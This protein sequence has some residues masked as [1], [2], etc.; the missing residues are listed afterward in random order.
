MRQE[1]FIRERVDRG[2]TVKQAQREYASLSK[3]GFRNLG[4]WH[5]QRFDSLKGRVFVKA[6]QGKGVDKEQAKRELQQLLKDGKKPS[7]WAAQR[8][9]TEIRTL[10]EY[11][12]LI[13]GDYDFELDTEEWTSSVSYG[14]TD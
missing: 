2:R 12:S 3:D 13:D 8:Y 5:A 10:E 4:K 1:D 14:N 11:Q 9:K 7:R 6:R